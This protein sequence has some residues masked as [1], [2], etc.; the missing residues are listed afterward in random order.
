V[1]VLRGVT[2]SVL[3]IAIAFVTPV[4]TLSVELAGRPIS[5]H[6]IQRGAAKVLLRLEDR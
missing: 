3:V 5:L 6:L 2:G 4:S 1:D